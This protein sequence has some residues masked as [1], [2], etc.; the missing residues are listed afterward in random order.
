VSR[1][2]VWTA[3]TQ[4]DLIRLDARLRDRVETE[5]TRFS[6][7][8]HSDVKRL[9]GRADEWRLQV[10]NIRVLF[11]YDADTDVITITILRVLPRDRAD[12]D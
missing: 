2:V 12:R 8:C 10:G 7:T 9:Q 11:R 5:V 3:R 6:T 1:P 4:D